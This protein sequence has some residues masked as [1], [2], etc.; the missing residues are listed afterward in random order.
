MVDVDSTLYPSDP[1]FVRGMAELYGISI[2]LEDMD[3]WGWPARYISDEQF[4]RLIREF[5]H[6]ESEIAAAVP[7][8]GATSALAAWRRAGHQV[9]IV[10]DRHPRTRAATLAWFARVG[11][12][13]DACVLRSPIDKISYARRHRIDIIIDDR[14]DTLVRARESGLG[15]ATLVYPANRRILEADPGIVRADNWRSLRREI[16]RRLIGFP[17]HSASRSAD[18]LSARAISRAAFDADISPT[19]AP[20]GD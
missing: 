3:E 8:P 5:F 7:F 13:Y 15:A 4:A 20:G 2:T 1:I 17:L 10:S 6:A 9:H 16:D 12:T 18:R 19:T 11:I 14:S